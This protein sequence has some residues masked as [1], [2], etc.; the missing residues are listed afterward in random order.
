MKLV[1]TM[2]ESLKDQKHKIDRKNGI[3]ITIN[4]NLEDKGMRLTSKKQSI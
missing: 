1:R 4:R 2:D 3:V